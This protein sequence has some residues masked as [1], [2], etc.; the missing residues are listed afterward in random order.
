MVGGGRGGGGGAQQ[1]DVI[2]R[3]AGPCWPSTGLLALLAALTGTWV[4]LSVGVDDTW[5]GVNAMLGTKESS[6]HPSMGPEHV[7]QER[8]EACGGHVP[9]PRSHSIT[10]GIVW[11]QH[12]SS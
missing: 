6:S 1:T 5:K 9:S 3:G 11:E 10:G 7:P 8:G 4:F 12:L 2:L